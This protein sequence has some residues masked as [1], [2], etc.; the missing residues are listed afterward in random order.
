MSASADQPLTKKAKLEVKTK[1]P[2]VLLPEKDQTSQTQKV[3]FAL[4]ASPSPLFAGDSGLSQA[5]ISSLQNLV[6]PSLQLDSEALEAALRTAKKLSQSVIQLQ[7][8]SKPV[9]TPKEQVY[10][11]TTSLFDSLCEQI[12][13]H[14][15]IS[16]IGTVS[17]AAS[18][19]VAAE[20]FTHFL[21]YGTLHRRERFKTI[22][23]D[24]IFLFG[25][26]NFCEDL[27]TYSVGRAIAL[28]ISSVKIC[29]DIMNEILNCFMLFNF[30]NSNLRRK[31][32]SLK[33]ILKKLENKLYEM[34]VVVP[35]PS[36]EE[37]IDSEIQPRVHEED[38]KQM[39]LSMDAKNERREEVIKSS[40]DVLKR[41]KR[42]IYDIHRQNLTSA[43][44]QLSKCLQQCKEICSEAEKVGYSKLELQSGTYGECM[45]EFCEGYLFYNFMT[46]KNAS[47]KI[48]EFS[49]FSENIPISAQQYVG[50]LV[51]FT[52]EIG[53]YGV[54]CAT[55]RNQTELRRVLD[56]MLE[57]NYSF[58][59]INTV[60]PSKT[61]KKLSSLQK[62][63][64]KMKHL[65]YEQVLLEKRKSLNFVSA[66]VQENDGNEKET[67]PIE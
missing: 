32:D 13:K 66:G 58:Q 16:R 53:R 41:S 47:A 57:I 63:I 8:E 54:A 65:L 38:F 21:S 64:S 34:S 22:G 31:Y 55:S 45:E 43:K 18:K 20:L 23:D 37:T 40:R 3:H 12:S 5:Y 39:A 30:R 17:S 27:E 56:T 15:W 14:R 42:A 67:D 50:A 10:K 62:N 1:E 26:I 9:S 24:S 33:Y 7:L 29:K 59:D 36:E 4:P 44:A 61:S 25:V 28:D 19:Y 11:A 35:L 51:D 6:K 52:G 2:K 48:R 49:W 60:L 46:E